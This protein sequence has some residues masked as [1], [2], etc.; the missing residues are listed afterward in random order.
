MQQSALAF[1]GALN[2][3]GKLDPRKFM[4]KRPSP[5]A[6]EYGLVKG[7]RAA[8]VKEAEKKVAKKVCD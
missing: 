4:R 1:N 8:K 2:P 5:A 7:K 6:F 3:Y